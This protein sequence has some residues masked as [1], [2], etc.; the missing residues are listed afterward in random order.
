[1][2]I[3]RVSAIAISGL[4]TETQTLNQSAH[5]VAN[6]ETDG[7]EAERVVA[8]ERAGGG[9]EAEYAPTYGPHGT[10]QR[11]DGSLAVSS[12]TDLAE[13]RVTQLSSLRA[14]QANIAVLRTSDE[15][16]GEL[17]RQKA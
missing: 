2:Q 15:M 8:R 9:V 3:G 12:N 1:M 13:E 11:D 4:R 7:F 6:A 16:L 14:F 10:T 5:N 17:V